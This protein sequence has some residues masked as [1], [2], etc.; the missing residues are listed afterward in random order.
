MC[1]KEQNF[2]QSF[3]LRLWFSPGTLHVTYLQGLV[4]GDSFEH[5]CMAQWVRRGHHHSPA[6]TAQLAHGQ[7]HVA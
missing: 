5:V 2:L 3:T 4:H 7:V 6:Q 1:L